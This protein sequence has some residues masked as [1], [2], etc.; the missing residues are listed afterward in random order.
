M[1]TY[2]QVEG[3]KEGV[4]TVIPLQELNTK[5]TTHTRMYAHTHLDSTHTHTH[6]HSHN[7]LTYPYTTD[8]HPSSPPPPNTRTHNSHTRTQGL[9]FRTVSE[10]IDAMHLHKKN[11][12]SKP[13]KKVRGIHTT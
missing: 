10:L 3:S 11:K 5:V 4:M 6:S 12:A 2:E 7:S 8:A 9:T 13:K 1:H